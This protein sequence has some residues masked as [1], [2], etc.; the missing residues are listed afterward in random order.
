M[1]TCMGFCEEAINFVCMFV[2]CE[3]CCLCN[4]FLTIYVTGTWIGHQSEVFITH[5]IQIIVLLSNYQLKMHDLSLS[6]SYCLVSI[7]F[8]CLHSISLL[9]NLYPLSS[10]I[11]P[12]ALLPLSSLHLPPFPSLPSP[13]PSL[14][15]LPPLPP[16]FSPLLSLLP[17]L[18]PPL[19]LPSF[20]S[21]PPSLSSP[22]PSPPSLSPSHSPYLP[23]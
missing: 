15:S 23:P 12:L 18:S 9:L 14:P 6:P 19:S 4:G 7:A 22:S 10:H 21:L 17:S 3:H 8:V 2:L 20:P 11:L 16:I 13:C 5:P 1:M